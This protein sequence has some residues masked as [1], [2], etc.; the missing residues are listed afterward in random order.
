[1]KREDIAGSAS[2]SCAFG[3][4]FRFNHSEARKAR[5]FPAAFYFTFQPP[6]QHKF[7]SW[8]TTSLL[9]MR[10][11]DRIKETFRLH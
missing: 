11:I 4:T 10:E 2:T 9:N 1:M 8:L 6:V 3:V 7:K 5:I